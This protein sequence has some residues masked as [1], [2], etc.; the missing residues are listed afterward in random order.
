MVV[1]LDYLRDAKRGELSLATR[2]KCAWEAICFCCCGVAARRGE[3]IS[4]LDHPDADVV[5]HL[6]RALAVS[7][8]ERPQVDALFR[9]ASYMQPLTPEPCSPVEACD[10]AESLHLRTAAFLS[11]E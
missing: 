2:L 9:W 8:D 4:S 10:P 7:P 5:E 1:S 6:L 3:C 11:T